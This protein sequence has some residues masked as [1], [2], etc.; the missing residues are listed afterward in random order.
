MRSPKFV[1][2]L[3]W[4]LVLAFALLAPGPIRA[5]NVYSD[6]GSG[7]TVYDPINPWCV[8]GASSPS[9]GPLT[10]RMVASSFTPSAN[11]NLTQVDMALQFVSGTNQVDVS[12][13]TDGGGVPSGT[14]L[15]SWSFSNLPPYN[16]SC[17]ALQ[18]ETF[19][20]GPVLTAGITYWLVASPGGTDTAAGWMHSST[21]G[22]N[23]LDY[24]NGAW[25]TTTGPAVAFDVIG[26]LTDTAVPEPC[27]LLL[28]TLGLT[29]ALVVK[30]STRSRP[31]SVQKLTA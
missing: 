19:S 15:A 6:L 1:G 18:T 7:T 9:C 29:V 11:Y 17:C 4:A 22:T 3:V 23:P 20:S 28:V 5:A 16:G 12:L 2:L 26:N 27:T 24:F 8:T 25:N 10:L 30:R 13:A 21:G 14:T 31:I